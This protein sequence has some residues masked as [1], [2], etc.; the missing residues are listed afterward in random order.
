MYYLWC[1]QIDP[2]SY[3]NNIVF[4]SSL[5]KMR[6]CFH[7]IAKDH[8]S[9]GGGKVLSE[10]IGILFN[11]AYYLRFAYE[12]MC[13]LHQLDGSHGKSNKNKLSTVRR[14]S[15]PRQEKDKAVTKSSIQNSEET[16]AVLS[17]ASILCPLM[18]MLTAV[19]LGRL[20]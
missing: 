13:D 1:F 12:T 16:M 19:L 17:N 20:L 5:T 7:D 2:Y 9:E 11:D 15:N 14:P 4:C 6:Q 10:L 3:L 8:C 18:H